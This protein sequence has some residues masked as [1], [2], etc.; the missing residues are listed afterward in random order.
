MHNSANLLPRPP[1]RWTVVLAFALVY[2]SWGTTYLAIRKGVEAF[3]PAI[4][5]G[6][7]VA[8]AGLILLLYLALRGQSLRLPWRDFLWIAAMGILFFVGGNGL[9]TYADNSCTS[10]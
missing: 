7:R 10:G 9:I 5:G 3:P 6:S 2:L 8:C 1:A 4:F